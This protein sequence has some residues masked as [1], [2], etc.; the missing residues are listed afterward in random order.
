MKPKNANEIDLMDDSVHLTSQT[1]SRDAA[2][3]ARTDFQGDQPT[4][5]TDKTGILDRTGFTQVRR[6]GQGD[7]VSD[8]S[9]LVGGRPSEY[10]RPMTQEMQFD[11]VMNRPIRRG[12]NPSGIGA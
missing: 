3:D 2:I 7:E 11:P 10:S 8:A 4:M 6:P 12:G 5:M 9:F 1:N